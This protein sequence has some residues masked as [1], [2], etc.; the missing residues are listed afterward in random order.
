MLSG[1]P[2]RLKFTYFC[3]VQSQENK[4]YFEIHKVATNHAFI[5][6]QL[7]LKDS[8]KYNISNLYK[9]KLPVITK[10]L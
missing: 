8:R 6:G 9:S 2:L 1:Y 5:I 7:S 3:S 10:S 4:P